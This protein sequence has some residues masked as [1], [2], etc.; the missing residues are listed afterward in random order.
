[1]L[2]PASLFGKGAVLCRRKEIRLFGETDSNLPVKVTL[3]DAEGHRLASGESLPAEGQFLVRLKPQE[4]ATGCSLI[5]ESAGESVVSEDVMIGDVY[6]AGGQSNMEMALWNAD[7]GRDLIEK[8]RQPLVRYF[9]VPQKAFVSE[10]QK[11]TVDDTEWKS[12]TPGSA[13]DMSAVAYF[14]AMKAA[15]EHQIPI[16]IIDCY[17]GGTSVTCWIEESVLNR[18][19]EGQHYLAEYEKTCNG[20]SLETFLEEEKAWKTVFDAWNEKVAQF[21]DAHPGCEWNAVEAE[22]GPCPWYPPAGPGSPYRPAGLAESMLKVAA[23]VALTGFLYYQGEADA[24]T[25]DH[26][27]ILLAQMVFY[28]REL[29]MDEEIPFLNI[30]LPMWLEA[31]KDDT[32]RWPM[33]RAAQALVR[34]RVRNSGL[35]CL[36]D[37]G[38]FNNIHP[39]DK[40]V[41]GERLWEIAK[42]VVYGEPAKV[43][44]KIVQKAIEGKEMILTLSEPVEAREEGKTLLEIREENGAYVPA[45]FRIEGNRL[46]LT[47]CERPAR[48]RYGWT[49]FAKVRLFGTNGLPLEPFEV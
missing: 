14:F 8:H 28:W 45:D 3:L 27:E 40:R 25:T 15:E 11:Q 20:K 12:I 26:Y 49:D 17:W 4:A 33:I 21:K 16:G 44:P 37:Q 42:G 9:N 31:G 6:L 19:A 29:F 34:D 43:S 41:V 23:P 13:G 38:E 36:L 30:Q 32:F 7:E 39:T 18:T 1:M 10:E 48:A 46:I 35:V 5:F 47:G 22:C 24:D 2:K